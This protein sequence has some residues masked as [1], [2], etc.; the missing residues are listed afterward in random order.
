MALCDRELV[1][2]RCKQAIKGAEVDL[3]VTH[4]FYDV[5]EGFWAQFARDNGFGGKERY[6][7]D[8][9]MWKD[10]KYRQFYDGP[11]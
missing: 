5:T 11:H 8:S 9:C 3:N 7:C 4:G 10:P 1:C 6:V 2:D